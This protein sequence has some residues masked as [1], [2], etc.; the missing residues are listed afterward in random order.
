MFG[1]KWMIAAL[2]VLATASASEAQ[3]II[4]QSPP[5]IYLQQPPV[6]VYQQPAPLV[7]YSYYPP[8]PVYAVR[9]VVAYS[10]P[11]PVYRVP[12]AG[13]YTTYSYNAYG[14]L[15]PRGV[16]TQSYYTPLR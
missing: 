3:L 14:V 15:R 10:A 5:P 7:T 1:T 11:Q 4:V 12:A 13:V 16:Y 8:A 9:P 2:A 6:L